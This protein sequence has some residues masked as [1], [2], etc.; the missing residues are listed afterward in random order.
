MNDTTRLF[1]FAVLVAVLLL[2]AAALWLLGSD[3]LFLLALIFVGGLVMAGI[4]AASAFPIR[5]AR[6]RDMTGETH[7]YHDGTRTVKEVK[8]LDGRAPA[9]NDIKLLQLPAAPSGAAFPEML[10]AAYES[11]QLTARSHT[12][13]PQD[14]LRELGPADWGDDSDA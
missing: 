14:D 2:G 4:I 5:A 11:G 9:Q 13:L 12:A 8:V 1:L 10:R 7:Y 6:K 3:R